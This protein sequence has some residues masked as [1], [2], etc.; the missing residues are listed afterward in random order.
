MAE[1]QWNELFR[2]LDETAPTRQPEC[3]PPEILAAMATGEG[4]SDPAL[5]KH[6]AHCGACAEALQAVLAGLEPAARES[7]APSGSAGS[8][9]SVGSEPA[10]E[11]GIMTDGPAVRVPDLS[12]RPDRPDLPD[13]PGIRTLRRRRGWLVAGVAAAAVVLVVVLFRVVHRDAPSGVQFRTNQ[14]AV[15]FLVEG[16][17]TRDNLALTPGD[18]LPAGSRFE[19]DRGGRILLLETASG[20]LSQVPDPGPTLESPIFRVLAAQLGPERSARRRTVFDLP[21]APVR[22]QPADFLAI[23]PRGGIREDRPEF[24]FH[25]SSIDPDQELIL[26][27]LD[28]NGILHL[29]HRFRAGVHA[30]TYPK[31][32]P[33]LER[34]RRYVWSIFHPRSGPGPL[35]GDTFRVLGQDSLDMVATTDRT[36]ETLGGVYP[37]WLVSFLRAILYHHHGLQREAL[38]ALPEQVP[39]PGLND[40]LLEERALLLD[41]LGYSELVGPLKKKLGLEERP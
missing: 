27:V 10:P 34:G 1:R 19:V 28:E 36:L 11:P 22:I 9:R 2:T 13:L 21:D 37:P 25:V 3:P 12:D 7:R 8:E 16:H 32:R 24:L 6:V 17:A 38:D 29:E 41:E 31:S 5:L 14:D 18:V 26:R 4:P 23:Q 33:P 15:V 40:F 30:L 20:R 35:G 39:D